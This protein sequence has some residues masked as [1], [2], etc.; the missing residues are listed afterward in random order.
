MTIKGKDNDSGNKKDNDN[1]SGNKSDNDNDNDRDKSQRAT[2][3]T[4]HPNKER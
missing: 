4:M 2:T 3:M 1:D